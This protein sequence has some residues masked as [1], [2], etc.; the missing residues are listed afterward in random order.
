MIEMITKRGLHSI[1]SD[2]FYS[3]ATYFSPFRSLSPFTNLA[4][5]G[6]KNRKDLVY[7]GYTWTLARNLALTESTLRS[8][9]YRR[10]LYTCPRVDMNFIFEWSTRYLT[11]ERSEL[12]RYQVEQV[13]IKFLSISGH[14]IF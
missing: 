13:K 12:V 10:T 4:Y 6:V 8:L 1:Y 14:V 11:S 5:R 3:V 7:H 2:T 9:L